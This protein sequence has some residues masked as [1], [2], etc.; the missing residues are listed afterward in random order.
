MSK[1]VFDIIEESTGVLYHELLDAAQ[2]ECSHAL[3][4]LQ[5]IIKPDPGANEVLNRLEPFRVK[6]EEL[7]EWPGTK[8]FLG[9]TATVMTY[10]YE[11]E[12]ISVLHD[13]SDR[14][15]A[16]EL[17][18]LPEDLCLLRVD[19][20][21]WLVTIAHERDSYLDLTNNEKDYLLARLP[22]LKIDRSNN[23]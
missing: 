7:T 6:S 11:P 4:V 2:E 16:W 20:S 15:Y 23:Q 13:I 14:L 5:H 19:G 18:S 10:R 17:P 21:P 8:L 3:L 9:Y 22:G 12:F 1:F